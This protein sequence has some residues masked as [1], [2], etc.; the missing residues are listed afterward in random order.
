MNDRMKP[1]EEAARWVVVFPRTAACRIAPHGFAFD[2]FH[3][4]P[5]FEN[6]FFLFLFVK[7]LAMLVRSIL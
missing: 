7:T 2:M 4:I 5:G 6:G 1:E 3:A